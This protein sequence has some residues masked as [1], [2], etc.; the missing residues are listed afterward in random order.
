MAGLF[1]TNAWGKEHVSKKHM[2]T[3]SIFSYRTEEE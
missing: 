3:V 2:A 1:S